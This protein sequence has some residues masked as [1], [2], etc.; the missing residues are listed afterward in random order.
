MIFW[1]KFAVLCFLANI[2]IPIE[3]ERL[4]RARDYVVIRLEHSSVF[5]LTERSI[6]MNGQIWFYVPLFDLAMAR[7]RSRKELIKFRYIISL[8][9]LSFSLSLSLITPLPSQYIKLKGIANKMKQKLQLFINVFE[10]MCTLRSYDG[11]CNVIWMKWGEK[12]VEWVIY[13]W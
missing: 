8:S 13:F 7:G 9:G 5:C 10:Y 1:G 11:A 6:E 2:T 3:D 4:D 12:K